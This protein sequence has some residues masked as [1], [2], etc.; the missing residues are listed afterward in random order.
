MGIARF[1]DIP[2]AHG[3]SSSDFVEAMAL[4]GK[5]KASFDKRDLYYRGARLVLES[6]ECGV[7][8]M[9]AHVEVDTIVGSNCIDV[10]LQLKRTFRPICDIQIAGEPLFC[11]IR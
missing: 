9:R 1:Y 3:S 6:V 10:G 8:C 7:T 2:S 4:T 11:M 5:A